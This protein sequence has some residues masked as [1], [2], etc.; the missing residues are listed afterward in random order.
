[1]QLEDDQTIRDGADGLPHAPGRSSFVA[2]GSAA[3]AGPQG[4][5]YGIQI[6]IAGR[7]KRWRDE[8]AAQLR[9]AGYAATAVDCGLDALSVLVLGLPVDVLVTDADLDGE[10][11][12][13]QLALEARSLRPNLSI[14]F[15]GEDDA[16]G[17]PDAHVLRRNA[18]D[19]AL[20]LTVREALAARAA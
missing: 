18:G 3:I 6:L 1:M 15:A 16:D 7:R 4:G 17:L 2:G 11:G 10:L 20:T 12:C 13:S 5:C 14:V 19:D 9:R 8:V